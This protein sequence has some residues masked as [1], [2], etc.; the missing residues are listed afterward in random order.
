[1]DWNS[2]DTDRPNYLDK[3][4]REGMSVEERGSVADELFIEDA[5]SKDEVE[6]ANAGD[7]Q[8]VSQVTE[9]HTSMNLWG[10][11]FYFMT[12]C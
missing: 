7:I 6:Y 1:M 9:K 5:V 3:E 11:G 2:F 8:A 10:L 4:E 12:L